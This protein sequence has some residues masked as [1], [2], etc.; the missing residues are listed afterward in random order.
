MHTVAQTNGVV[1][2]RFQKPWR[3]V[4]E[5]VIQSPFMDPEKSLGP[6]GKDLVQS[7]ILSCNAA[8]PA[9]CG[10][11]CGDLQ[12]WCETHGLK[13]VDPKGVGRL[14]GTR[15]WMGLFRFL[16]VEDS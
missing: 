7:F 10:R 9:F 15:R 6:F 13:L 14:Y 12:N 2:S 4:G 11:D 3:P 8:I 5:V 16:I 1:N